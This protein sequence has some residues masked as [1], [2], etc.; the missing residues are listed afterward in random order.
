MNRPTTTSLILPP[1]ALLVAVI[2]TSCGG[3]PTDPVVD[4]TPLGDA[5]R[6]LAVALVLGAIITGVMG[7]WGRE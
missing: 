7:L 6:F 4:V 3:P 2:L 5:V 1:L